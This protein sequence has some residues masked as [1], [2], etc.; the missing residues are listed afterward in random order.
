VG[1]IAWNLATWYYGLPSSSSHALVGGMVGGAFVA[2]GA[3]AVQSGGV[4]EKVL[5][6]GLVAPVLA[7]L[8]GGLAILVAYRIVGRA[9]PGPVGRGFRLGQLLSS[10][11]FS[12][13]HGTNDAQKTM[14][15]ILLALVA[16]GH[17]APT[18][19]PPLWVVVA[20]ATAIAAGT[21]VGGWRIIRTMG[22]RI[23]RMDPAQGFVAQGSG[24]AVILSAS[25]AGFPLST[26][27]VIAGGIMGVGAA[28]RRVGGALGRGG[29][30]RGGVGADPAGRGDGRRPH[31]R[32]RVAA[33]QRGTRP[34]ARGLRDARGRGRP[35]RPPAPAGTDADRGGLMGD[36]LRVVVVATVA[37]VG[38]SAVY[39]LTLLGA[40]RSRE[41]PRR[42]GW[43]VLAVLGALATLVGVAAGIYAVAAT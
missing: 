5:L 34:G 26:T 9:H 11:L 3:D 30:H 32:L 13:S 23:I 31:L 40:I 1:A 37:G 25:A 2:G 29:Q 14:G 22:T 6:P 35:A 16:A 8:V 41:E 24:A 7:M 36:L 19:D 21:Y 4:V 42:W 18:D 10:S 12:F 15:V 38:I 39:S 33:G 17:A 27:H 20:A 43:S 28:K